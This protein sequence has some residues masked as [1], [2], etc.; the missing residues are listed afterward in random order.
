[1]PAAPLLTPLSVQSSPSSSIF[2]DQ[3]V[4][5]AEKV[6]HQGRRPPH[7]ASLS[8]LD[9]VDNKAAGEAV[10][11]RRLPERSH[12]S[13]DSDVD[14][15]EEDDR[16][17]LNDDDDTRDAVTPTNTV[18]A[19]A[20]EVGGQALKRGGKEGMEKAIVVGKITDEKTESNG[21][22]KNAC[23]VRKPSRKDGITN[24]AV[25]NDTCGD[26][27]KYCERHC[28]DPSHDPSVFFSKRPWWLVFRDPLPRR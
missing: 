6:S 4:D 3:T 20:E 28:H 16:E 1:M 2:L 5:A 8:W 24:Q 10:D 18:V 23:R 22:T 12:W 14:D 27:H 15:E 13:D 9:D 21:N 7:I 26:S 25:R 11:E 17:H 19:K